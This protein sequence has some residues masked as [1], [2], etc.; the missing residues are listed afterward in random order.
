MLFLLMAECAHQL[1]GRGHAQTINRLNPSV[2]P[3]SGHALTNQGA[4]PLGCGAVLRWGGGG[5]KARALMVV[6][7]CWGTPKG[8]PW[9]VEDLAARP[10]E[11]G[12]ACMHGLRAPGHVWV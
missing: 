8:P 3:Q 2:D 10:A 11:Q 5:G 6:G 7:R 9:E 4:G 12:I 1:K